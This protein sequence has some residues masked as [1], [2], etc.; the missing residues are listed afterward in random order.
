MEELKQKVLENTEKLKSTDEMFNQIL[1]KVDQLKVIEITN[2]GGR[3]VVFKR[4]EFFQMLYDRK[5]VWKNII[6]PTFTDI[7]LVG[8]VVSLLLDKVFKIF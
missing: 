2:G 5:N 4:D 6:K 3:H 1:D 7:I 8:A